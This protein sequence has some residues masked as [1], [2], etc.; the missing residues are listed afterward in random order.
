LVG[1]TRGERS[2]RQVVGSISHG[3]FIS[4]NSFFAGL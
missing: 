1:T 4:P 3:L 2:N